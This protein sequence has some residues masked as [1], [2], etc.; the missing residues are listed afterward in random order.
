MK[1]IS[2]DL[3]RDIPRTLCIVGGVVILSIF[4]SASDCRFN[5]TDPL[6]PTTNAQIWLGAVIGS[7]TA[8]LFFILI[9]NPIKIT[10]KRLVGQSSKVYN[11]VIWLIVFVAIISGLSFIL[12][13]LYC[14]SNLA[15]PSCPTPNASVW[16]VALIGSLTTALFFFMISRR[17]TSALDELELSLKELG[18]LYTAR[19]CI[20]NLI[21]IFGKTADDKSARMKKSEKNRLYFLGIL[22]K[23]Y[24]DRFNVGDKIILQIYKEGSE[25]EPIT[26]DH[27]HTACDGCKNMMKLIKEFNIAT[28]NTIEKDADKKVWLP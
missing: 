25:H 28:P 11:I 9:D 19:T 22:K 24:I 5:L 26:E 15:D 3:I 12:P 10:L 8:A 4:L 23:N 1:K 6:C 27:D 16:L 13:T 21:D 14:G 17:F 2:D 7:L 20:L 18:K